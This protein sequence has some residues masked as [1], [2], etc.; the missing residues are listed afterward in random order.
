VAATVVRILVAAL[1]PVVR[2]LVAALNLVARILTVVLSALVRWLRAALSAVRRWLRPVVVVV[3]W[4]ARAVVAAARF[5]GR[6]IGRIVR[7]AIRLVLFLALIAIRA[8]RRAVRP[9]AVVLS[10]VYEAL[11][12][13]ASWLAGGLVWALRQIPALCRLA[14][15]PFRLVARLALLVSRAVARA[16]AAVLRPVIHVAVSSAYRL[17]RILAAAGR[18]AG[19]TAVR[20]VMSTF[21]MTRR[22]LTM[23]VGLVRRAIAIAL[24]SR[25]VQC[26]VAA[27][28]V[29]VG[30]TVRL[31]AQAYRTACEAVATLLK[32]VRRAGAV[33]LAVAG[34][35]LSAVG[36]R[37]SRLLSAAR[38]G[39]AVVVVAGIRR[40]ARVWMA[41]RYRVR[42][43]AEVFTN[44]TRR[45]GNGAR[46][47]TGTA[48]HRAGRLATAASTD[49]WRMVA[50]QDRIPPTP[51]PDG[52]GASFTLDVH[53]NAYLWPAEST[54]SAV[55]SVGSE[56]DIEPRGRPEMVEVILLDCSASM[57][58]PWDKILNAR[59]ATKAAV[60]ALPDGVW[61]A[62][63]RGAE[64][65][66]VAYPRR[67]GLVQAS[68]LTRQEA[69][70]AIDRLQPSG[71]TA[72]GRWLSIA[73]DLVALRPGA[74]G[75]ALLLTDGKNEDESP[76]DLRR[77]LDECEGT[78]QCDCRGV[79]TD[80]AVE[81]LRPVSTALL[82]TLDIIREPAGMEADFR[83]VIEEAMKRGTE[84]WLSIR[85]PVHA[86]IT[87]L[88]QV[89]PTVVDLMARA[90]R[91][92]AQTLHVGLGGWGDDRR[93]YHL[94][95]DVA[96]GPIGSE[97]AVGRLVL[98]VGNMT[99]AT[100]L[101]RGCWTDDPELGAQIDPDVAHYTGQAELAAAVQEG[102]EAK[103]DGDFDEATV[104]LGRAV[105]LA[106]ASEHSDLLS[107]LTKVV[108]VVDA[109]TGRV[110]LRRHIDAYDEMALDTRSTRTVPS[111]APP[112]T[113]ATAGSAA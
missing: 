83:S 3:V 33:L 104:K 48:R 16:I 54:V 12:W 81:E 106:A 89:A 51:A 96:P 22:T 1:K 32:P 99:R 38:N 76:A 77:A 21:R 107:L 92:D 80:W 82:G 88:R 47:A 85:T 91:I 78:F 103:R 95:V 101:V 20:T 39:L 26:V 2:I 13:A 87:A 75:H 53:Q 44:L 17:A 15:A 24:A 63:V 34:R 55:I 61:F 66:E 71:G 36:R 56:M 111:Q 70:R 110:I 25:L 29:I 11:R 31:T 19:Q 73:R 46:V 72:I 64:A 8:L 74:L 57:A 100:G 65:A 14:L 18:W 28:R 62:V 50:N 5:L 58:H 27:G 109:D 98:G 59:R 69:F 45:A 41:V 49:D 4:G 9:L 43:V 79:G 93:E 102:L 10:R 108:D 113:A 37:L 84:A 97:M 40:L 60:A 23:I 67:D 86:R 52:S 105:Q 112:R 90:R 6:R 94:T 42:M 7:L 30:V 68:E 35:L